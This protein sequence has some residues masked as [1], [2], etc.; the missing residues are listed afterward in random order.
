MNSPRRIASHRNAPRRTA[1]L[2][3]APRRNVLPRSA[4]LLC[5]LLRNA[6]QRISGWVLYSTPRHDA[7]RSSSPRNAT[8]R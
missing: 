1:P 3:T 8:Q 4:P 7:L 6:T 5:S 2:L